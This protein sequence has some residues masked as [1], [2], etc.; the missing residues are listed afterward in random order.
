MALLQQH[1]LKLVLKEVVLA[2][3]F[4]RLTVRS[5]SCTLVSRMM[6]VVR[7]RLADAYE[8][9]QTH[10]VR[11]AQVQQNDVEGSDFSMRQPSATV[12]A[13]FRRRCRRRRN[14]SDRAG[15]YNGNGVVGV[16]FDE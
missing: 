11:Q 14:A 4:M 3:R 7:R 9:I 6:G 1:A 2:P 5:S 16:V 15:V 13:V 8:G 12:V 10:A